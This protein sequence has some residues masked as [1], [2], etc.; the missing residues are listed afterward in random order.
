[1]PGEVSGGFSSAF[2]NRGC[3]F[4]V[5]ECDCQEEASRYV[6]GKFRG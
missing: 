5:A 2:S 1:M 3:T 6:L 4:M